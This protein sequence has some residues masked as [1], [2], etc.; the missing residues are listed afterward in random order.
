MALVYKVGVSTINGNDVHV[1]E[2]GHQNWSSVW[3]FLYG[4]A[5]KIASI[6]L[7]KQ[8]SFDTLIWKFPLLSTGYLN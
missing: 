8:E 7:L 2:K 1:R 5:I 4:G 3:V 6:K